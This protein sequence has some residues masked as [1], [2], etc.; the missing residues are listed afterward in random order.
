MAGGG[1]GRKG[2]QPGETAA[3]P[4]RGFGARAAALPEADD[5]FARQREAF[6]AAERAR[7][8]AESGTGGSYRGDLRESPPPA[9]ASRASQGSTGSRKSMGIAYVLWFFACVL[10]AHRFYLGAWRSAL[11]Q[12]G[13]FVGGWLVAAITVWSGTA[14]TGGPG[15]IG[16]VGPFTMIGALLWMLFDAFLIPGLCKRANRDVGTVDAQAVFG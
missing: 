15:G 3:P 10:S 11:V 5:P 14:E 2:L 6:I 7:R 4:A 9:R 16:L 8:A 12:L 13:M 1:F